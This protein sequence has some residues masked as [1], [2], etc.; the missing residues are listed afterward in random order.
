[1]GISFPLNRPGRLAGDVEDAA[2]HYLTQLPNMDQTAA[3]A[4][5][6]FVGALLHGHQS[7]EFFFNWQR[8]G[9]LAA[10]SFARK[11]FAGNRGW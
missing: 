6:D 1:M 10:A 2:I 11:D 7:P 3:R 9:R 4:V 8:C 5:P